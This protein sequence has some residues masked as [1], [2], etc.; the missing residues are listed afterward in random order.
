MP[1]SNTIVRSH[2]R[3]IKDHILVQDM[4]FKERTT[5]HGLILQI[6]DGKNHGIRPR[7][8]KVYAIGPEQEHIK[9]GQWVLVEH[10]RWTRGVEIIIDGFEATVRRIDNKDIM[11]VYEGDG[12]PEDEI[13]GHLT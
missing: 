13:L 2:V 12:E 4:N 10:G 6:D 5:K 11:G 7:W 1:V 8:A 9:I 3:A